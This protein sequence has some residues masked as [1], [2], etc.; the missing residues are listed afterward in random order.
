MNDIIVSILAKLNKIVREFL[1]IKAERKF[2]LITE[3][4]IFIKK[5]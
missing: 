1:F 2:N 3:K 5:K 4:W